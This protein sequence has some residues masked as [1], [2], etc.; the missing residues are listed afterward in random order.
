MKFHKIIII[1][2]LLVISS[3]FHAQNDS[4]VIELKALKD[5][6]R[7]KLQKDEMGNIFYYDEKQKARIY[8]VNGEKVV[9]MDE[10]F[11]VSK[12]RFNNDLED[13]KSVV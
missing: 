1:L 7:D 11:L 5:I 13:R 8:E 2:I 9:M 4:I 10:L 12:P 3:Q 6:P